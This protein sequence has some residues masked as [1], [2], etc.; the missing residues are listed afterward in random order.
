M[1]ELKQLVADYRTNPN[2][3]FISFARDDA[4][5]LRRY[6]ASKGDFGFAV[7]PLPPTL[8]QQFSIEGYPTTAVIDRNGRYVYDKE[9]Y[10]GHLRYLRQAIEQALR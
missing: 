9:G 8:A 5:R 2:V 1:P 7:L 3:V 6:V 4:E 10:A